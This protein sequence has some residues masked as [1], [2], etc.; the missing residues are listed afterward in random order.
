VA[1]EDTFPA[2]AKATV[3]G[4]PKVTGDTATVD[5]ELTIGNSE[6]TTVP[7]PLTKKDGRWCVP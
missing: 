3:V 7:M 2:D 4:E 1:T 5:I 6:P